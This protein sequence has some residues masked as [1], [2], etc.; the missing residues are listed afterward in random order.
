MC[1]Q[2]FAPA[3]RAFCMGGTVLLTVGLLVPCFCPSAVACLFGPRHPVS[4]RALM[5]AGLCQLL[6]SADCSSTG[7]PPPNLVPLPGL[8]P[9]WPY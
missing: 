2:L 1:L 3:M 8:V 5:A 9:P 7:K 4:V 6:V